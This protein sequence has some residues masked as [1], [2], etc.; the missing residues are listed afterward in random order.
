MNQHA[1]SMRTL[2]KL[3]ATMILLGCTGM[4]FAAA[5][6]IQFTAGEAKIQNAKQVER[7]AKK[8]E[9]VDQGDTI[10]TGANGSVQVALADG[11]LLAVRPNTQMRIDAYAYSGKADDKNNKS[12]F[13][14][15]R[16]AF[17]SITGAIGKNNKEAYRVETPGAT[18]G[19]RGTDHEPAVI[20]PPPPGLPPLPPDAPRPG[21]YDRVNSGQTFIQ[22]PGGFILINP[23]QAGFAP[24]GG[25]APVIL[26]NVPSFY[27]SAPKP[28]TAK[29]VAAAGGTA[30]SGTQSSSSGGGSTDSSG[31]G[32]STGGTATTD[33]STTT[34]ATGT[35]TADTGALSSITTSTTSTVSTTSTSSSTVSTNTTITTNTSITTVTTPPVLLTG[36]VGAN[37][38]FNSANASMMGSFAG[39][40]IAD[41]PSKIV[42]IGTQN[43]LNRV[44]DAST[45]PIFEALRNNAP[46]SEQGSFNAF[47]DVGAAVYWGRWDDTMQYT[48][49][50]GGV[51]NLA[52]GPFHY[53][54]SPDITP[55]SLV[56]TPGALTGGA[57]SYVGGTSPSDFYGNIGTLTNAQLNVNFTTQMVTL[58]ISTS[59]TDPQ[60]G[61]AN[62]TGAAT[63][64]IAN[65]VTDPGISGTTGTAPTDT[66]LKANGAFIG[67]TASGAI[68]SFHLEDNQGNVAIG[69]AAFKR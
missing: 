56:T 59:I 14:L 29:K 30:T 49:S 42:E 13:S 58:N 67:A 34:T 25:G 6:K 32:T 24:A 48:L 18:M 55:F 16:G 47:A 28:R 17:R 57:Y 68:T 54:H 3:T 4:A 10:V 52:Q 11:G 2:R 36:A 46:I 66:T 50:E 53:I 12:F 61:T 35:G 39:V 31:S 44:Y 63:G 51:L 8:G 26:P 41:D 23:N 19:I 7:L 27:S 21:T 33:S 9:E 15:A 62:L 1:F 37:V 38:N 22:T 69:T 20:L 40:L 65:F 60:L 43:E 45:T 64:S 5:G